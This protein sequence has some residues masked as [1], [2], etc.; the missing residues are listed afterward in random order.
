MT[1]NQL[2]PYCWAR[3][4][5]KL[6]QGGLPDF[7]FLPKACLRAQRHG[8]SMPQQSI[9][10]LALFF[11]SFSSRL[12]FAEWREKERAFRTRIHSWSDVN[13][14]T[15]TIISQLQ[16]ISSTRS[17]SS[18][19]TCFVFFVVVCPPWTKVTT[20]K[21]NHHNAQQKKKKR[22]SINQFGLLFLYY[23]LIF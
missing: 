17:L 8:Y 7:L 5:P 3:S 1:Q 6:P 2:L 15:I 4:D 19:S 13:V 23:T 12:S 16:N 11:P 9:F 10:S 14:Y 21:E 20:K 18:H 22:E